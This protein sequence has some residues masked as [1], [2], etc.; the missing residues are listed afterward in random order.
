MKAKIKRKYDDVKITDWADVK[1]CT[2]ITR[3]HKA[4]MIT[5]Y[6]TGEGKNTVFA[7]NGGFAEMLE[8]EN[9]NYKFVVPYYSKKNNVVIF[10]FMEEYITYAVKVTKSGKYTRTFAMTP[11]FEYFDLPILP[12][13]LRLKVRQEKIPEMGVKWIMY[14]NEAK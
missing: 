9:P 3:R 11:F 13:L 8:K 1:M 6:V 5:V 7:L 14:L 4:P 12:H 10:D 2:A